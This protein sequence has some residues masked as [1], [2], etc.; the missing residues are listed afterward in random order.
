LSRKG[1]AFGNKDQYPKAVYLCFHGD[2]KRLNERSLEF[3]KRVS[4]CDFLFWVKLGSGRIRLYRKRL[5]GR[6]I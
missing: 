1:F 5:K 6:G 4:F 3:V 2:R